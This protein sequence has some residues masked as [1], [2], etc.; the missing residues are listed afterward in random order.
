MDMQNSVSFGYSVDNVQDQSH[1]IEKKYQETF[2]QTEQNEIKENDTTMDK[3]VSEKENSKEDF[4][5]FF[6]C[7]KMLK[8]LL[9]Y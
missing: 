4:K 5:L 6:S 9:L 3:K 2:T 1:L 7:V 8:K